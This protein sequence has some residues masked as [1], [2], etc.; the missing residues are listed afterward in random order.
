MMPPLLRISAEGL[1]L[2]PTES[3]FW[4][5]WRPGGGGVF[6]KNPPPPPKKHKK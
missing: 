6:F 2:S 1:K 5:Y 3:E 4:S